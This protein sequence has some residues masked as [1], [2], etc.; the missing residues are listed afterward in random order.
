MKVEQTGARRRSG[1]SRVLAALPRA[2]KDEALTPMAE[3]LRR[4]AGRDPGRERRRRRA[5]RA[6]QPSGRRARRPAAARRG[7]P[8]RGRRRSVRDVAALPDP[9][10]EIDDGWRLA[11]RPRAAQGARAARRGR[12]RL[13]GAAQR[14][15]RR[16][17]ALPQVG[18]RRH[19][20]R[21]QRRQHSNR[22]L[23]EV[24]QGAVLEAGLP[25]EAVPSSLGP[26]REELARAAHMQRLTSTSSS[27]AAARSSR[28]F[29]LEHS[30]VPVIYAAGGNCHVYV[31]A[32]ADLDMAL[33]ITVNAKCQRPGVCNAAETL[34]VHR[35]VAAAFLPRAVGGAHAARRRARRRQG[36][37]RRHRPT[38][39]SSAP[40][41]PTTRPSSS[42]LKLAVRVVE[43][44]DEAIEHIATYGTRPLRGDR[45][46][47]TS[48]P[49]GASPREVDAAV[50]L[51]QRL[52]ALHRRRPV[53]P[54]RRDGHLHAEAAR[55]R[56]DRAAA[57][58]PASS[59]C[60]GA[61][62]R[63]GAERVAG[64]AA[65]A[66]GSWAAAST[67]RTSAHL[68][69]ASEA[70]AQLGL[71]R[72]CSSRRPRRRTRRRRRAYPAARP[73]RDDVVW[74]STTTSASRRPASR[75]SA[76]LRLHGRHAGRA[77]RALRG[78]RRSSSS[79]ARTRCCSSTPG[80]S[81]SNCSRSCSLAVAPRPGD[82]AGGDRRRR[83]RAGATSRSSCSTCRCSTSRRPTI[84]DARAPRAADP[85]PRAAARWSSSSLERGC[86]GDGHRQGGRPKSS[87]PRGCLRARRDA[88][89][90]RRRR[91]RDARAALRRRRPTTAELAGLLHDLCRELSDEDMLA[92]RRAPRHPGRPGRGAAAEEAPARPG[93]GRGARRARRR[94]GGR[95]RHPPAHRR[96]GR[97]ERARRSAC[98]SPTTWSPA[99]T[100]PASTRCASWRA[101]SLDA[102]SAPPP[103]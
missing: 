91:G 102:P 84:R 38:R 94:P 88:R 12:R 82:D 50:R 66:W 95:R 17:R 69:I 35:D 100:S 61:T 13:R 34:L 33:P 44:L 87:W 53:R 2:R 20:A 86:T 15:R 30:K 81:R 3:A 10:G 11:E 58:S 96:R 32:A 75:S 52:H 99:A 101:T 9:V 25:R 28:S 41:R 68:A 43:S 89:P 103:A 67:R 71:E 45:H 90:S 97:H 62:G 64:R 49:P 27:R 59:T 76:G 24:V 65:V 85:L 92:A 46:R 74:P 18:Q 37:R 21:R 26:D 98:I 80:T 6:Q 8:A 42:T 36:R 63:C 39:R 7:P 1:A 22:I 77:R 51:R 78:P 56:P 40:T 4:R 57:S 73:A 47:A 72:C 54:G 60:C 79:S 5:W 29:L 14:D 83:G 93:G 23:A 16:R 70:C 48:T 19:P 55:P 31:D